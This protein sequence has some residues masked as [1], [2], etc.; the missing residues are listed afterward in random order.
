VSIQVRTCASREE[1]RRAL[2]PIWHYF[3]SD[4]PTDEQVERVLPVLPPERMHSVWEDGLAV[5]GAGA[6]RFELAVPGGRVRAAGIM[7]VGVLPTHRRRGILR[8]MMRAQ[9]DDVHERGEPVAYL[10]ASED[11]LYGRYGYGLASFSG[12]V[13]VP[14]ERTTFAQPFEQRGRASLVPLD[15]ALDLVGPVY[16][17]V[18]LE[19]PGMFARTPAWWNTRVLSDPESRRRGGGAL[20]CIAIELDGRPA[21]YALYRLSLSFEA[22]VSAGVVDVVEA[23]ADSPAATRE[24][25]RYLLDVDWMARLKAWLLPV[26]HP[27]FFLVAEP[28]RLRFRLRDG[29]WVRLVDVEAALAARSYSESAPVVL[30][31][32]DSFCPWNEGRWRVGPGGAE[33]TD[34]SVDLRLDVTALGSVYLGGFT[35]AQ[36]ERAGRVEALRPGALVA[37][38]ALF[39]TDRAPWCP[40]IF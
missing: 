15:Q 36:L 35:F 22:G 27:L 14:R 25:W 1:V 21:A 16:E 34:S 39:R 5:G 6:Y 13:D 4:V 38:D 12:E 17:R 7:G 2:A 33:R 20:Q 40:E 19:T 30:E 32:A 24:I 18:A 37:A 3:G 31:V 26:D 11:T 8:A 29:L 10:W 28:R 9:L 23:I